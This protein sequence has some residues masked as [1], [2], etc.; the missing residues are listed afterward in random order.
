MNTRAKA[1]LPERPEQQQQSTP[2]PQTASAPAANGNA[3]AAT[4]GNGHTN[5]NGAANGTVKGPAKPLTETGDI[6]KCLNRMANLYLHCMA[7]AEYVQE[8]WDASKDRHGNDRV[9]SQEKFDACAGSLFI[10]SCKGGLVGITP[11]GVFN[12]KH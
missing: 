5:G 9:M 3:P 8:Q 7:A 4:N 2:P 11:T 6:K 10:E 1:P 12:E